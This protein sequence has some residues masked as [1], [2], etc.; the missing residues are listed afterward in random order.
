MNHPSTLG[1]LRVPF[2][3]NTWSDE[4][5][6]EAL[7]ILSARKHLPPYRLIILLPRGIEG[8]E[9][10]S[11]KSSSSRTGAGWTWW[12]TKTKWS[13]TRLV[14][15]CAAGRR[16]EDRTTLLEIPSTASPAFPPAS[17]RPAPAAVLPYRYRRPILL[18]IPPPER[19]SVPNRRP[20]SQA[21]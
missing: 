9:G 14:L 2:L 5:R 16:R 7:F 10:W 4:Q 19:G 21:S 6:M 3:K 1:I 8:R 13:C 20:L 11:L 17:E 12:R 15:S 18:H